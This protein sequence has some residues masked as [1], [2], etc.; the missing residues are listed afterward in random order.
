MAKQ[1]EK[2]LAVNIDK[3]THSHIKKI[4]VDRD[5]SIKDWVKEAIADKIKKDFDLGFR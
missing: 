3:I 5:I 2:R 1:D 4:C